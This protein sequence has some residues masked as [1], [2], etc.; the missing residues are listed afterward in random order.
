MLVAVEVKLEEDVAPARAP[1]EELHVVAMG[2]SVV[3]EA[4]VAVM[5]VMVLAA[6]LVHEVGTTGVAFELLEMEQDTMVLEEILRFVGDA[7]I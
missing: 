2:S 1:T 4:A 3:M 7:D 5:T 6:V